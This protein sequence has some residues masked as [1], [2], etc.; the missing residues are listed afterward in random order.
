MS[1]TESEAALVVEPLPSPLSIAVLSDLHCFS[2]SDLTRQGG[3]RREPSFFT[4]DARSPRLQGDPLADLHAFIES[5]SIRADIL[6]CGGDLGDRASPSGIKH[7]WDWISRIGSALQVKRI[8]ATAGNHDL[9]HS[10]FEPEVHLKVL[11]PMFPVNDSAHRAGYWTD[12]FAIIDDEQYRLIVVN[13]S[14]FHAKEQPENNHGRIA[15]RT[16]LQLHEALRNLPVKNIQLL[17]CHHHPHQHADYELG[18]TDVMKLGQRLLDLLGRYGQWLVVHGHKHHPKL[19]HAAGGSTAPWVFA[20]GSVAAIPWEGTSGHNGNQF[21]LI[22]MDPCTFHALGWGGRIRAWDWVTEDGWKPAGPNSGL[23]SDVGFGYL[24][25]ISLLARQ[26]RQHVPTPGFVT[27]T[28]LC[29][30]VP[31]LQRLCPRDILAL[32]Q[33]SLAIEFGA[34][35]LPMQVATTA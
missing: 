6:L 15:D 24:G 29:T 2:C 18:E 4:A 35:G 33:H 16:L 23:P 21:Y 22:N 19:T 25:S 7:S 20:A 27:W 12:H 34:N 32:Q 11:S 8:A 17:L 30:S 9:D 1:Q 26:V 13:S 10:H 5:Q 28:N 14:A 31:Q 3:G